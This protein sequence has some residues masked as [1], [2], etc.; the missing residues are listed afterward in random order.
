M[1]SGSRLQVALIL[2]LGVVTL[3]SIANLLAMD[4]L[5]RQVI[6]TR[7]AVEKLQSGGGGGGAAVAVASTAARVPGSGTGV[8]AVGW[9]DHRAEIL[10]VEGAQPGAPVT[11]SQKPRPRATPTPTAARARPRA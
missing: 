8:D 4:R 6:S 3:V 11:L 1:E 2:G 10:A 7:Q 9:G 5:E